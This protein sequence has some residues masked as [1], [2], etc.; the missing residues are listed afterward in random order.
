V[1]TYFISNTH[2]KDLKTVKKIKLPLQLSHT[3]KPIGAPN[4]PDK[5]TGCAKYAADI[6]FPNTLWGMC[7]RSPLPHARITRIDLHRA[8]SLPGVHGVLTAK[9]LPNTLIGR[10]VY[11]MPVLAYD[12]IRFAGE[13]IAVVAAENVDLAAEA[14]SLIDVEYEELR[15]VF[16]PLDA[17]KENAPRLHDHISRYEN[18]PPEPF[19]SNL[20]NVGSHVY[21]KVGNV[22]EGF[23]TSDHIFEHSFTTQPM[24]QSYLEPHACTVQ[25]DKKGHVHIYL[26]TKNPYSV[27]RQFSHVTQHPPEEVTVHILPVGGDFGAKGSVMDAPLCYHLAKRTGRPVKMV[28]SYTEELQAS[29]PRHASVIT[30]KTGVSKDGRILARQVRALWDSGAYTGFK[31]TPIANLNGAQHAAGQYAIPHVFIEALSVNTNNPPA[32]FMRSPGEPQTIFAAES[33]IDIIAHALKMDPYEFRLKNVITNGYPLPSS[34][35][36]PETLEHVKGREV[37]EAGFR[38]FDW[39]RPKSKTNRGRGMAFTQRHIGVG[40]SNAAVTLLSDGGVELLTV[41]PDTGAGAYAVLQQ[42]VGEALQIDPL[43]VKIRVGTTDSF[44][45]FDSGAAAN[46]VTYVAGKAAQGAI[47]KLKTQ[48][49]QRLATEWECTEDKIL[50]Q[51]GHCAH[52]EDGRRKISYSELVR[53]SSEPL[54]ARNHF[55]Q[56]ETPHVGNFS[57][58]FAEVQV[59]SETGEYRVLRMVTVHDVGTILNPLGHQGQIDG[60]IVQ[61]IGYC[62]MEILHLENGHVTNLNL[63]DYKIPVIKDIPRLQTVLIPDDHGPGPFGGKSVGE[64]SNTLPAAAIANAIYDATGIRFHSLPLTSESL[65]QEMKKRASGS[66]S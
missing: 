6:H 53:T 59:D 61:G 57:A 22:E 66:R 11:D 41:T 24:H 25:I 39:N 38:V 54:T 56:N 12:H 14:I 17:I 2:R 60:G 1:R 21:W 23:R 28:M 44:G 40:M 65:C 31:P 9:D 18:A 30:I 55:S 27:K 15:A 43:R 10:S 33:Q 48:I 19:Q 13:R 29:S 62:T 63:G 4:G 34:K 45:T 7:L 58:Q 26:S 32:G 49:R 5:V 36:I 16:D 37:L 8:T 51:A 50:F 3:F 35:P 52:R 46:R 64:S 20:S 42:V 47:E